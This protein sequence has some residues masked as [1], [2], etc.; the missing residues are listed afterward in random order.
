MLKELTAEEARV[1]ISKGTERPFSGQYYSLKD[2]GT[3]VCK[4][5]GAELFKSDDKFSSNCGWPSF[6]DQIPGSVKF[7]PDADGQ[8]TEIQCAKC[9]GHLGHIFYGEGLTQK[10][11]RYCVNSVSIDFKKHEERTIVLGGG[12]FWCIEAV[13]QNMPGVIKVASGYAGGTVKDPSYEE[14]CEGETGHAEVIKVQYNPDKVS[15]SEIL[16]LFFLVH[17]PTTLNRQ[18]AD[19]GTQYRSIIIYNDPADKKL[20]DDYLS[21]IKGSYSEPIVTEVKTYTDFYEAED[22]HKN[23]Y[24]THKTQPY[25]SMVIAPKVKKAQSLIRQTTEK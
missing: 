22:Y 23:Y 16:E 10:N 4:Q 5:C 17:D 19:S 21:K 20:I 7:L 11:A 8:R 1:I 12:C 2:D 9:G 18:G 25:C 24:N 6:D 15:L 14:V 13:F 3:Y